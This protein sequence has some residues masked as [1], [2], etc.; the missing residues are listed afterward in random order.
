MFKNSRIKQRMLKNGY[1]S[2]D[3]GLSKA[4]T[5][6]TDNEIEI[7]RTIKARKQQAKEKQKKTLDAIAQQAEAQIVSKVVP[8][9]AKTKEILYPKDRY[10][11]RKVKPSKGPISIVFDEKTRTYRYE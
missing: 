9:Q 10:Y 3:G 4:G 8:L 7:A 5:K 6:K 2:I 1:E 11:N